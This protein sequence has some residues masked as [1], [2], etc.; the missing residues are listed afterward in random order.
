MG[1]YI[2]D[3]RG[4]GNV[5]KIDENNAGNITGSMAITNIVSV[6][7]NLG[8]IF[9]PNNTVNVT[10]SGTFYSTVIPS[11]AFYNTVTPSGTFYANITQ[12]GAYVAI[13]SSDENQRILDYDDAVTTVNYSSS[14]K[15]SVSS[16]VTS[17]ASLG[18]KVSDDYNN[19]GAT[20]LV[21]S[22]VV[23]NV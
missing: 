18:R 19:S 9:D 7:G 3:G 11:G 6:S 17:S 4:S 12:S 20:T 8:V 1:E 23:A 10:P 14:D 22:R 21:I 5:W 2:T 15:D 13:N 16:I